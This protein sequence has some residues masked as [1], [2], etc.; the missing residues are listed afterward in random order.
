MVRLDDGG[1]KSLT[2]VALELSADEFDETGFISETEAGRVDGDEAATF[3]DEFDEVL[4]LVWLD[5]VV[6]G[7]EEDAVELAQVRKISEG[8]LD[9]GGVVEVNGI[10]AESFGEDGVILVGIVGFFFVTEKENSDGACFL[11]RLLRSGLGEGK[12]RDESER[13]EE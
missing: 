10:S 4:I 3:L 11:C 6:V 12:N 8:F 7:V 1:G 13:E 2:F 9:G 5:P